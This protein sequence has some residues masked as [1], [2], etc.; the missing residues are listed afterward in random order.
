LFKAIK[1]GFIGHRIMDPEGFQIDDN[2]DLRQNNA[3]QLMIL[4]DEE[5]EDELKP[6]S[7]AAVAKA[8]ASIE[9]SDEA[10]QTPTSSKDA[11]KFETPW[12]IYRTFLLP[13]LEG[14]TKKE[15]I[16]VLATME[17]TDLV[18]VRTIKL[19][20]AYFNEDYRSLVIDFPVKY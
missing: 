9:Q 8:N 12:H 4:G 5:W 14:A 17:Q 2:D 16:N 15:T 3:H 20:A 18:D 1:I 7:S 19:L 11:D 6:S 10:E 13:I